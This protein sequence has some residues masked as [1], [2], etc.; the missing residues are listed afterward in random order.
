MIYVS[1]HP[2]LCRLNVIISTFKPQIVPCF[3]LADLSSQKFQNDLL[4]QMKMKELEKVAIGG[5][6]VENGQQNMS[7]CH[8][9]IG[10]MYLLSKCLPGRPSLTTRY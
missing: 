7:R 6:R 4:L 5:G 8:L 2:S 9:S 3:F 1:K 10:K